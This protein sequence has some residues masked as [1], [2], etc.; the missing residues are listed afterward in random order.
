MIRNLKITA[1]VEN[2]AGTLDAV[3]EWGLALWIEADERRILSDTGQG[4]TLL[5]NAG[6]LGIGLAT[7]EALIISHGHSE[8][9]RWHCRA[10]RRWL[11]RQDL[12]SSRGNEEQIP[13]GENPSGTSEGDPS[14]ILSSTALHGG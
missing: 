9:H 4:H 13:T 1:I 11:S 2:T 14:G 3:G 10:D 7:A 8:S 5:H 12:H 6:L